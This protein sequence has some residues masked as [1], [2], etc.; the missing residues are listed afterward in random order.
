MSGETKPKK[1]YLFWG[2][3]EEEEPESLCGS[4]SD[5]HRM[6]GASDGSDSSHDPPTSPRPQ[7][8]M[9]EDLEMGGNGSSGSGTESH[10][11]SHSNE[12]HG[13]ESVGSSSRNDK[14]SAIVASSGSN[15][16]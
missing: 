2:V 14:D 9:H 3:S 16:R 13:N 10:N 8:Q 15:K 7:T 4:M 11:E 6:G 12:S 5:L 1:P